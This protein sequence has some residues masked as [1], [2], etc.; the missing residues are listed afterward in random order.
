MPNSLAFPYFCFCAVRL[1]KLS[2]SSALDLSTTSRPTHVYIDDDVRD[3]VVG[4]GCGNC[5]L[6]IYTNTSGLPAYELC[7]ENKSYVGRSGTI[8]SQDNMLRLKYASPYLRVVVGYVLMCG[9]ARAYELTK[10]KR[11]S[12]LWTQLGKELVSRPQLLDV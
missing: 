5:V 12:V 3:A 1:T 9:A 10:L 6:K 8:V 7:G 2:I 4:V 11:Y